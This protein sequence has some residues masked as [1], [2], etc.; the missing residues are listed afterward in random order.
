MWILT[1][2]PLKDIISG[3]GTQRY[4]DFPFR[5][6]ISIQVKNEFG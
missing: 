3:E 6:V 5:K 1:T 4:E 2:F